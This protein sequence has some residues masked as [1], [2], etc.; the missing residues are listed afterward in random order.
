GAWRGRGGRGRG[1]YR[2]LPG[3]EEPEERE[4]SFAT[5]VYQAPDENPQPV[6]YGPRQAESPL[7]PVMLR[8][9][10]E[11]TTS[12][13]LEVEFLEVNSALGNFAV[14]PAKLTIPPGEAAEPTPMTSRLGITAT[15]IPLT[16]ALRLGGKS[17]K[18]VLTLA[19]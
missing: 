16:V 13:P 15:E 1:A 11:N 17:D 6:V 10:L 18:H 8:L 5:V 9:R 2:G 4:T 3:E 12:E 14:Y 19:P 7:P